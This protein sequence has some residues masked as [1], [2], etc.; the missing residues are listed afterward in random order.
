MKIGLACKEFINNDLAFNLSQMESALA[1]AQGRVELLCLGESFLQ[2]FDA[3]NWTYENDRKIAI[4]QDGAVMD[5]I[6]GLTLRYGVDLLFGYIEIDR[7]E[8]RLY[9]AC[10]VMERGKLTHNYRRIS[11][12]WKEFRRT[13]GHYGE[14][15]H[16]G[17]FRYRG[18]PIKI[19]LC[20]DLWDFPERFKTDGLL[21]WPVYVNFSLEEWKAYEAEYAAQARLAAG[22]ALMVNSISHNPRSFG[23]AFY[24]LD[25]RIESRLEYDREGILVVDI[26]EQAEWR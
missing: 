6:A 14:G 21:I 5:Q 15:D 8:E 12:G 22:R 24:F 3:L 11:R 23:G 17:G 18:W 25:G 20:G 16:T 10:A 19:A 2:G 7:E 13:D 1:A 4:A 26:I 9:S